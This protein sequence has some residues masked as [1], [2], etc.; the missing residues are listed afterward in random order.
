MQGL[1]H[2]QSQHNT[3]A[4]GMVAT[5][6]PRY[7]QTLGGPGPGPEIP[8]VQLTGKTEQVK[9]VVSFVSGVF[10]SGLTGVCALVGISTLWG[11]GKGSTLC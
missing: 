9:C 10:A 1:P 8:N 7:Y 6:D 5:P 11:L 4:A 3:P 2:P